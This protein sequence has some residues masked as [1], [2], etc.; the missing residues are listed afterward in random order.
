MGNNY[1]I[2]DFEIEGFRG[3]QKIS[4]TGLRR[5]NIIGGFNG[6]GKT[7]LLETIFLLMDVRNGLAVAKP[8]MW[9]KQTPQS[10]G[11][12]SLLLSDGPGRVTACIGQRR[13]KVV[14]DIESSKIPD[15]AI[16]VISSG[17]AQAASQGIQ[18][19]HADRRNLQDEFGVTITAS[20]S[21]NYN[22]KDQS[23]AVARAEG[24]FGALT[25]QSDYQIPLCQFLGHNVTMQPFEIAARV[26]QITK[27]RRLDKLVDYAKL[28]NR[29][30]KAFS[31]LQEAGGAAVYVDT[32]ED[33][34]PIE[35]MG[36]GFRNLVF[37]VATIMTL[38]NGV[39]LL[40]EVDA[41]F[42]H[43]L[44]ADAWK[45]FSEVA[46]AENCQIFA[47]THS[48]EA[49]LSAAKGISGAGN[50]SDFSYFRVEFGDGKHNV[51]PYSFEEVM[52]AESFEAEIR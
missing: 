28:I 21:S 52:A 10:V 40:D 17:I 45:V 36:D 8:F 32:G 37:T 3:F 35:L 34:L 18:V 15:A 14:L 26:S 43:S 48:R 9:R 30:I 27:E 11:D 2:R 29:D 6:V 44:I 19:P 5:I 13:D 47:C 33:F 39:V 7:K 20:Y 16:A 22:K 12:L 49:I 38:K 51:I 23:F 50:G 41:S 31:V 42:H 46:R 24:V 1:Y 25:S 4:F